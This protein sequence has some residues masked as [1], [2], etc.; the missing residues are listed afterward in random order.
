MKVICQIVK[1]YKFRI[2]SC[3]GCKSGRK[4]KSGFCLLGKTRIYV[5]L[6]CI[7]TFIFTHSKLYIIIRKYYSYV[8]GFYIGLYYAYVIRYQYK[9][10]NQNSHND[11]IKN[12]FLINF[13][14]INYVW[15]DFIDY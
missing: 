13:N 1:S 9:V 4:L 3:K 11:K 8:S 6:I 15:T 2:A 5:S 10:E 7:G 12:I 14:H